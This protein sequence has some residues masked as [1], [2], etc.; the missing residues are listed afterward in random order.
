MYANRVARDDGSTFLRGKGRESAMTLPSGFKGSYENCNTHSHK[1]DQGFKFLRESGGRPLL[2]SGAGRKSWCSLHNTPL[3]DNADCRAQQQQRG[4]GG[5]SGYTRGNNNSG[6][7]NRRRHGSGS[8]TGRVN[9]AVTAY[10]T[11][12]LT[13]IEPALTTPITAPA[14]P[15]TAS[16]APVTYC[17]T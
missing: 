17:P 12:S 7:S 2:L 13:V 10:G 4:N 6:N 3:Y 16:P 1:K 15:V 8:N 14:A 9:T 5:G 11:S